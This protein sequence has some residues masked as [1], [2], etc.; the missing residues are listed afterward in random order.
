MLLCHTLLITDSCARIN[1][2]TLIWFLLLRGFTQ[3]FT[4]YS[5]YQTP[6][7]TLAPTTPNNPKIWRIWVYFWST[8]LVQESKYQTTTRFAYWSSLLFLRSPQRLLSYSLNQF[9][10]TLWPIKESYQIQ[11][12]PST[13][14]LTLQAN[15]CL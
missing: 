11:A 9:E 3:L 2:F 14:S 4:A 1:L 15:S 7:S 13:T 8:Y 5:I 10:L 6:A 12:Q